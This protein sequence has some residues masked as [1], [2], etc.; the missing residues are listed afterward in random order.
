MRRHYELTRSINVEYTW[1]KGPVPS[2]F[3]FL[4][5]RLQTMKQKGEILVMPTGRFW[6]VKAPP[7]I[8]PED[9]KKYEE[10]VETTY[11]PLIV[12]G[13]KDGVSSVFSELLE[14]PIENATIVVESIAIDLVFSTRKSFEYAVKEALSSSILQALDSGDIKLVPA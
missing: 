12:S 8:Y 7:Y 6:K 11:L 2:G 9:V 10:N 5:L 13:I 1:D 4:K 14:Y 3:A